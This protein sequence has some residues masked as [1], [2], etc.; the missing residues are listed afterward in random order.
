MPFARFRFSDRPSEF[1]HA[2]ARNGAPAFGNQNALNIINRAGLQEVVDGL[3]IGFAFG[4]VDEIRVCINP[5][6]IELLTPGA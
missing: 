2:L 6:W 4:T 3:G 1:D 5:I